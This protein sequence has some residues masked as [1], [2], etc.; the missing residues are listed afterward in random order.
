MF[1]ETSY[2]EIAHDT[3]DTGNHNQIGPPRLEDIERSERIP[4]NLL[5]SAGALARLIGLQHFGIALSVATSQWTIKPE[6]LCGKEFSFSPIC[7]V[8]L[9]RAMVCSSEHGIGRRGK[10]THDTDMGR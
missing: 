3:G 2:C 8:P 6:L 7:T 9:S 10:T 4:V 5:E 1:H